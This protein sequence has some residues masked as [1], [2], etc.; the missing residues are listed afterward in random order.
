[1][2]SM[3]NLINIQILCNRQFLILYVK[4]TKDG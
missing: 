4:I 3:I 1:M 2:F